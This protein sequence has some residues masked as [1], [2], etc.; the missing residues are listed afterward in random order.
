MAPAGVDPAQLVVPV[1]I[2]VVRL[3][4]PRADDADELLA[5]AARSPEL[6]VWGGPPTTRDGYLAWIDAATDGT[7]RF[8]A[9]AVADDGLVG[10]VSVQQ[11]TG[12]RFR[13]GSL[14]YGGFAGYTR[15][16]LVTAAVAAAVV[17]CFTPLPDGLGLHRVEASIQ[18]DNARS[19]ALV[20]RLGFRHEGSSPRML[21]LDGAWRDHE[22][23]A[24]TVEDWLAPAATTRG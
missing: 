17:A 22:R 2:G 5:A 11:I 3:A 12:L 15:R 7:E 8:L 9:R 4:R 6:A 21:F 16:G 14:G 18:P 24:L 13:N 1:D 23:F 10:W 20:R 19:V